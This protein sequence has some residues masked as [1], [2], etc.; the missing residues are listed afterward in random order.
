MSAQS[1]PPT[2]A[3]IPSP[4]PSGPACRWPGCDRSAAEG[5]GG[6]GLC[7]RDKQ[8]VTKGFPG[9]LRATITDAEIATFA[10]TWTDRRPGHLAPAIEPTPT[11]AE[12]AVAKINR[13][14]GCLGV[15]APSPI[16]P[17]AT[18]TGR[19]AFARSVCAKAGVQVTEEEVEA[20]AAPPGGRLPAG[21][22]V[23]VEAGALRRVT[24]ALAEL[25]APTEAFV[26]TGEPARPAEI[27]E[28]PGLLIGRWQQKIYELVC[29]LVPEPY[30]IDGAGSDSDELALTLAEV[31]QGLAQLQDLAD[32]R[33]AER[34]E[35]RKERDE[36][37]KER[38]EAR[39]ERDEAKATIADGVRAVGE[40]TADA[41]RQIEQITKQRDE[42]RAEV[43]DLQA[44]LDRAS[45]SHAEI[46]VMWA[47]EVAA[48]EATRRELRAVLDADSAGMRMEVRSA[49]ESGW[50]SAVETLGALLPD[51]DPIRV[52]I[53]KEM[54]ERARAPGLAS[55]I[56]HA[57]LSRSGSRALAF[58]LL[59]V[60]ASE[61]SHGA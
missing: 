15:Q 18:A 54:E 26:A 42:A 48:H 36:A 31:S 61:V 9:R 41:Q 32:E 55:V 12:V 21:S 34:D 20:F 22:I 50:R 58:A 52:G 35:A 28:R 53:A 11:P 25:G 57:A 16:D 4:V 23:S 45:E 43:A 33:E 37:R 46:S 40:V 1:T 39:K 24:E 2:P 29:A 14:P 13:L 38:D 7:G 19:A 17:V 10:A 27:W 51:S 49:A 47:A 30:R 3:P 5:N 6:A 56:E 8:R 60:P 44:R 59:P